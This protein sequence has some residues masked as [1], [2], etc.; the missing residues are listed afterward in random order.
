VQ[1]HRVLEVFNPDSQNWETWDPDYGVTYIDRET[2]APADI[3]S[4]VFSDKDKF[5]PV[6]L[7]AEGW[8]ETKSTILK[9]NYF[10]SVL[11]EQDRGMP[12]SLIIINQSTFDMTKTFE[13]G[14]T[15]R[16]WARHYYSNPRII[17]LPM[18]GSES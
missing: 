6:G 14:L 3:M 10:K 15:F 4:L 5:V 2:N 13:A 12:N 1:S 18:P 9:E 11:F 8:E 17:L 16:E 7:S